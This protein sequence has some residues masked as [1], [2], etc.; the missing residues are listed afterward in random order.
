MCD[1]YS[2]QLLPTELSV[3]LKCNQSPTAIAFLLDV[4][5]VERPRPTRTQTDTGWVG[6]WG[7]RN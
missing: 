5:S 7:M 4:R 2:L 1:S 6:Q 3:S